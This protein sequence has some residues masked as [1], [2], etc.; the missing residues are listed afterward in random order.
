MRELTCGP[1][2]IAPYGARWAIKADATVLLIVD[3]REE[4]MSLAKRAHSALRPTDSGEVAPEPKSF[5]ARDDEAA[6]EDDAPLRKPRGPSVSRPGP[7]GA[8]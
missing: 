1:Y 2:K 3:A 5:A 4:A 6:P 8:P 7:A